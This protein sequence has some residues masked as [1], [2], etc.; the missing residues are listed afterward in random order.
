[1]AK[2]K[3]KKIKTLTGN[4]AVLLKR[5]CQLRF[6]IKEAEA[7]LAQ[8]KKEINLRGPGTYEN[9][10][11]NKLKIVEKSIKS[12]ID[13][14]DVFKIFKKRGHASLILDVVDINLTALKKHLSSDTIDD[15]QDEIDVIH[16][17]TWE[18]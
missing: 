3:K 1:M 6:E 4:K 18:V 17:W 12:K 15:L 11:G 16:A 10:A 5:G 2:L 8:I 14:K 7:Q 13:P 9:E